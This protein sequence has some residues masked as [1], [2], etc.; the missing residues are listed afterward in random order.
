VSCTPQKTPFSSVCTSPSTLRFPLEAGLDVSDALFQFTAGQYA[1][2]ETLQMMHELDD[3]SCSTICMHGAAAARAAL[4]PKVQWL[5]SE[6]HCKLA[7][8]SRA[9]QLQKLAL[10]SSTTSCL[11]CASSALKASRKMQTCVPLQLAQGT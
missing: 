9:V 3:I 4:L 7:S 6:Q 5:H 1:A 11:P 8:H 10:L 2:I